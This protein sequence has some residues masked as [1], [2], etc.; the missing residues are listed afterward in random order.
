[1]TVDEAIAALSDDADAT[2]GKSTDANGAGRPKTY[3]LEAK[4]MELLRL[5]EQDP[6]RLNHSRSRP[7]PGWTNEEF[8]AAIDVGTTWFSENLGK[9][10]R[11]LRETRRLAQSQGTV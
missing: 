2:E 1:M 7:N 11:S 8:I 10:V 3:D 6:S 9:Y 4:R 5:C